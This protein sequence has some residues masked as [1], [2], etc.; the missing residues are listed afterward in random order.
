M[1]DGINAAR[2]YVDGQVGMSRLQRTRLTMRK[3]IF[4]INITLDGCCDHT[5]QFVDEEVH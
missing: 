1:A 4:G 5:T 3:L 2:K